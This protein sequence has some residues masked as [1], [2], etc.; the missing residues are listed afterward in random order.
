M[1]Y[2]QGVGYCFPLKERYHGRQHK[3]ISVATGLGL[4][5]YVGGGSFSSLSLVLGGRLRERWIFK[6][7]LPYPLKGV[8]TG[9]KQ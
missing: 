1:V 2:D 3:V 6:Y 5:N 9:S 7:D 8:S 4:L